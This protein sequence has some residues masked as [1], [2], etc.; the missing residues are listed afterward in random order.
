[1]TTSDW[2]ALIT[3]LAT[4]V[5]LVLVYRQLRTLSK[6]VRLQ[7]YSDYTKRYQEIALQFPEDIR[8]ADFVLLGRKDYE[9][10]MRYMRAYFDLC[11][12]EWDLNQKR[13][14]DSNF[15]PVWQGAMKFAFSKPAFQQAWAI[16]K[17]DSSFGAEFE[18]F[19]DQC[20]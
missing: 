15:W 8:A 12:E 4:V 3:A 19:V 9:K 10:T 2:F 5:G 20:M 7:H 17:S 11:F 6:Q 16:I 13:L 14:I 1:M 18:A